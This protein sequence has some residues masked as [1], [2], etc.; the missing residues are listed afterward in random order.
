MLNAKKA[1]H[2]QDYGLEWFSEF[3]FACLLFILGIILY[4]IIVLLLWNA[5][6]VP[7]T[8]VG[9][10]HDVWQMVGLII[11]VRLIIG[12]SSC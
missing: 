1:E 5:C 7:L 8:G 11:A 3:F 4:G 12:L 10:C 2:F 9:K 6:L